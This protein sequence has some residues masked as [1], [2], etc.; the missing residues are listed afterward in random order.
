MESPGTCFDPRCVFRLSSIAKAVVVVES[1]FSNV[2]S[3]VKLAW[4]RTGVHLGWMIGRLIGLQ[5]ADKHFI[6]DECVHRP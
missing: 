2:G 1:P 6:D 3:E 4:C 5:E